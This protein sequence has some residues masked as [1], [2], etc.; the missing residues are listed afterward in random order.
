MLFGMMEGN[1]WPKLVWKRQRCKEDKGEIKT[2]RKK[3]HSNDRGKKNVLIK[4]MNITNIKTHSSYSYALSPKYLN[5]KQK[6][7]EEMKCIR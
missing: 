1:I 7:P 3:L 4:R 6:H 2:N 5:R